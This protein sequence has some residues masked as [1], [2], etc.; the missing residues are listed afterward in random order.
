MLADLPGQQIELGITPDGK[1]VF[2]SGDAK[3]IVQ[4]VP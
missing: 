4:P 2:I 3:F 1:T